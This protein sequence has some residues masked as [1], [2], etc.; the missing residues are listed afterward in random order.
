MHILSFSIFLLLMINLELINTQTF[1]FFVNTFLT[2]HTNYSEVTEADDHIIIH[3]D[4]IH[5]LNSVY[6]DICEFKCLAD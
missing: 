3:F 5:Y 1:Y 4:K 2:S 6:I